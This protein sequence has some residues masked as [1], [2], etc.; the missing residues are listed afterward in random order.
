[1]P[2]AG[3]TAWDGIDWNALLASNLPKGSLESEE[4]REV[5]VQ[6]S[7]EKLIALIAFI[8]RYKHSNADRFG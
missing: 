7:P 5:L 8:G 4:L 2:Q 1:L 3:I 6:L